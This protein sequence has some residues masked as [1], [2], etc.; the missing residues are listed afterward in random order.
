LNHDAAIHLINETFDRPFEE[1]RFAHFVSN[2]LNEI[3]RGK[4]TGLRTGNIIPQ[5]FRGRISAYRRLFVYTDPQGERLDVLAVRLHKSHSLDRARTMQRNFIASYLK[6]TPHAQPVDAA[7]VAFYSDGSDESSDWRFSLV[8][9]EY[10]FGEAGVEEKLTP[11]RRYSYLVGPDEPSHTAAQQL[12]PLLLEDRRAP[13]LDELTHAFQVEMVSKQFFES[14]RELFLHLLEALEDALDKDPQLAHDFGRADIHLADFAKK[15]LGQIVFLYFV[16]KKGW[17]GVEP[18]RP[19][20]SGSK[21]YLRSLFDKRNGVSYD[22]FFDDILEPLFYDALAIQRAG[23]GFVLGGCTCK[24]PFLNG[25]LFEPMGGYDWQ[26]THLRLPDTLFSNR[27]DAGDDGG[28]GILDIF[29]RYNFTVREEE[30][31]EKEVAVDPEMLGKVFENLLEVRDR[32]SKGAFYTPR[33]IVHYMC[34]ESL[35]E[36]LDTA[37][38]DDKVTGWQGDKVKREEIVTLV[39]RGAL[40]LQQDAAKEAGLQRG[41]YVLPAA[42]RANAAMLDE[43]LAAIK[44]CDLAIGSGAFPV[45]MLHEIVQARRALDTRL[46]RGTTAYD[47]K[48]HA[49]QESIYGVD[50]DAGAVEIA[51]LRLWLSLVVDEEAY[52]AIQP[53]PNLDY[54]IVQGNSLGRVEKNLFNVHLFADLDA[55]KRRFFDETHPQEKLKL[56]AQIDLLIGQLTNGQHDFDFEIYFHEVFEDRG[57]FDVMVGNPP[58][59]RQERIRDLKP[60]LKQTFPEV[61]AGT[62]DLYVYFYAQGV[63]ILRERGT[64]AYISSNKFM[65]AGYGKK[66]RG[67]LGTRTS[68]HTLIDFGD[69]PVFDAT[70]Y[71]VIVI[72]R[73]RAP[74]PEDTLLA[75]N[76]D[77]LDVL[78]R[79]PLA[80]HELA[81][82]MPQRALRAEG[83]ALERPEVLALMEKLRGKGTPLAEFVGGKF[84]YGIKTGYN[85]AFV[86]D[87]ATRQRL[88]EEDPRSAEVIK[89]WLRGKD[90][91]RWRVDWRG[92]YVIYIRNSG[93]AG[94]THPW[95]NALTETTA[96]ELFHKT[97][98]AIHDH[99]SQYEPALRKRQDQGRFWWEL[100]ACAYYE[101]FMKPKIAYQEIATFHAFA[102]TEESMLLNNKCFFIPTD[103]LF[104]IGVLNANAIW[105]FLQNVASK[106]QGGALAMQSPYV[107]KIPIP[108]PSSQQR[109]MVEFLVRKLVGAKGQ[110][111]EVAAWERALNEIVYGLYGLTDEE[112]A[113]IEAETQA[114]S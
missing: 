99:L 60:L 108:E 111:P 95:A 93:D 70:A 2:L 41:E 68:L 13:T 50:I 6:Q 97:Y 78:Q 42:V 28:S 81:W 59:V 27:R 9:L 20:G 38:N 79:L 105:F 88:I 102:W 103:K 87:E 66:L 96:R 76:V 43:A 23:D 36:Y 100:R 37:V 98:P 17:L 74:G 47:L 22:N 94:V 57:G 69:L 54:K 34:Q 35:I 12:L 63:R 101:E 58:Y 24:I 75:L 40:A 45:G 3:D 5:A 110:G 8:R 30:P 92:L 72:T 51:K 33:E 77:S 4:A 61:Y 90:I 7:L 64:L 39:R 73:K 104:L 83:W 113:L 26:H 19:W 107:G 25:G 80:V 15:L 21:G 14:Y 82:P 84:Y 1:G 89:P 86:I 11:A 109:E 114:G 67:F 52:D 46:K 112:I 31:L 32:K 56:R 55:L 16:Q 44:L 49:I 48:R 91:K 65:R 53:L 71:P 62:A 18:D 85:Q 106:L 29:D 10:A